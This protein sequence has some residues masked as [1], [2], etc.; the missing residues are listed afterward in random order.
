MRFKLRFVALLAMALGPALR[1]QL[2]TPYRTPSPP[3]AALVDAPLTPLVA[4]SPDRTRLLLLGRAELPTVAELAQPELRLAGLRINPATNAASR[5]ATYTGLALQPIAGG[6]EQRVTGLPPGARIAHFEW[7]RSGKFLAFSVLRDS[8]LELW[9]ADAATATARAL[10]PP[11][12]NSVLGEPFVWLDESTLVIRRVPASRPPPPAEP[13]VP[14]GP[15][16]QESLGRRA[17]ARTFEDMLANAHDE[18]LFDYYGAGE[19]ALVDVA[20]KLSPLGV[21]GLIAGV[22]PAPDGRH[23][24]VE[25]LHRPFSY[26]VPATRFPVTID[27]IDRTGRLEHRVADLPLNEGGAAGAVRP[28]PRAVTW[29]ADAPATL[30]WIQALDRGEVTD[31]KKVARDG[32]FTHAAP[33]TEKPIEQ[34]KFEFRVTAVVWGD[35]SLA[36]VNESWAR[37]RTVRTWRVAPGQP[38]GP[39][40]LLFERSTQDRYRHPGEP[41]RGRNAFGRLG[42][43][44][45]ADGTKIFFAGAGASPDGDRPF[46][47][48][49]D[50]ATKQTRRLWRS[51]PPVYE[52][53]VA[54][55]DASL[56]HALVRRESAQEPENYFVR[57]FAPAAGALR[58]I[59][60]FANPYPQFADV[61][62][63]VLRYQRADGVALS[64]TLYLPPGWAPERGPLPTLIWAYPRE[65]LSAETA[66][67]ITATPEKFVRVSVTGP[68]PFLLAG[69]AV[70]NDPALPII[71]RAGGKPNDT[72]IEQLVAGAQ[73][74]VDELVRRGVTDPKRVAVGG[75]SY[76]A[77]MTANLLA[78]SRIFRA[79]IAESGAYNRTLTPFGFQSEER[80]LWQA[81]EVYAAMSPFNFADKVKDP[82]LLVHGTAD[83]NQGTF[84][85][86]SD[87]FYQA[88]K[89]HGATVRYVQLPYEAHGYRGRENLLH[90][91]WEEETWLDTYVKPLPTDRAK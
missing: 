22:S 27:V 77:F 61:K 83:N 25:T 1:A 89:G 52:E 8:G 32:W 74:A 67:Q 72:Y 2:D 38:G 16:V 70:L 80:T 17:A 78:H 64:G 68:L 62:S 81:P 91:L 3:I 23:L 71:A 84:P 15:V 86:Q 21:R 58:P 45:S 79:G 28:G 53:F 36:L 11:V 82:L 49:F 6:A 26:L 60:R 85:I 4:L 69:Y 59:T 12:L 55:T 24:L 13:R 7:S 5:T 35:D 43:Q 50:L 66:E 51:A 37:T 46:L 88:L 39:R 9:L 87:R 40:E 41:V 34:Q 10:T 75:H 20:G 54:F 90:K 42:L 47:D 33:F 63:E 65:F 57:E 29:R 56:D 73:A 44:R 18:A 14:A 31:E 19:L 76:G 30:S 48:E